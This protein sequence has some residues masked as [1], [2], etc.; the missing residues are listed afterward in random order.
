MTSSDGLVMLLRK[1]SDAHA[2]RLL[3]ATLDAHAGRLGL[4][5]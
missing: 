4:T 3:T 2:G 1:S 5:L